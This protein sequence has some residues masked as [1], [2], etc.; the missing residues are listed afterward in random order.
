MKKTLFTLCG[1]GF[2]LLA[3]AA[4]AQTASRPAV[5]L[6]DRLILDLRLRSETLDQEWGGDA[7]ALTLRARLGYESQDFEGWRFLAEGE[8]SGAE[9]KGKFDAY[10]TAQG[11][12]GRGQIYDGETAELNRA[13]VSYKAGDFAA[14][15]GRQRLVFDNAR[16]VGNVGWRQ[17]EQTFDAAL[18]R[19][20][21]DARN[22]LTYAFVDR[23]NRI[24][25]S[26]ADSPALR[27]LEMDSHVLHYS[28]KPAA[29][30]QYALYFYDLGMKTAP[31]SSSATYGGFY[32]GSFDVES[33][34]KL[35][36]RLEYARQVDNGHS[37]AG[38]G[39]GLD[40][41]HGKLSGAR[42]DLTLA[43]GVE[44]LEGDG[45][46]GFS[47]PLATLHGFNGWAD[48]FLATPVD[49]LIDQYV[50]A[51][52]AF[53]KA[54]SFTTVF[55]FFGAERGG[56]SYAEELDALLVWKARDDTTVTFKYANYN[57]KGEAP[58]LLKVDREK[59]WLQLDYSY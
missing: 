55:H 16:F 1:I 30:Q 58:G 46:T 3:G 56:L 4:A 54:W 14:V 31:A 32:E 53:A 33:G 24:F 52:Y 17:N 28:F 43:A 13:Q 23:A 18:A 2:A 6:E 11:S 7:E 44:S 51:S 12:P 8:F 48:A 59:L 36:G 38:L 25:G 34:W 57:G 41:W 19:F 10:P 5:E 15:V 45:T 20:G 35:T 27:R 21:F 37:P 49:G 39:F 40:Y 22:T 29:G 42:D 50:S 47:T 9:D 26:A